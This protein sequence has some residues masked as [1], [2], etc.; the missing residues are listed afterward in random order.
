MK[1]STYR[2]VIAHNRSRM[3]AT[4]PGHIA[5]SDEELWDDNFL[6]CVNQ[7]YIYSS[8]KQHGETRMFFTVLGYF[9]GFISVCISLLA[10]ARLDAKDASLSDDRDALT[11][12][13]VA[14][15]VLAL[16]LAY[17]SRQVD[18][19]DKALLR[20]TTVTDAE[21][22][23]KQCLFEARRCHVIGV[24]SVVFYS[25]MLLASVSVETASFSQ[26]AIVPMYFAVPMLTFT[27]IWQGVVFAYLAFVFNMAQE[28]PEDQTRNGTDIK[29]SLLYLLLFTVTELSSAL[30][31][32]SCYV[33]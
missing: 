10:L 32:G 23:K 30:A 16:H 33:R 6:C 18:L 28:T 25:I 2:I 26:D 22:W 8:Q 15:V 21:I 29:H 13:V 20:P 19:A 31:I 4:A 27:L 3:A 1:Q 17:S 12:T 14:V 24:Y 5:R 11:A 9:A 7:P